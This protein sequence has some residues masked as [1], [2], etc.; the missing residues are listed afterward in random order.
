MVQ[1]GKDNVGQNNKMNLLDSL[2]FSPE[3][4]VSTFHISFNDYMH[5]HVSP[6]IVVLYFFS[7]LCN[8]FKD[9][10]F[11]AK[12]EKGKKNWSL[13]TRFLETCLQT[14]LVSEMSQVLFALK[15]YWFPYR[16]SQNLSVYIPSWWNVKSMFLLN[17]LLILLQVF[18]GNFCHRSSTSS[19]AMICLNT[20]YCAD[21]VQVLGVPVY[22]LEPLHLQGPMVT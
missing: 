2:T 4:L 10:S 11:F 5:L 22:F 9:L 1:L 19:L 13:V 18:C 17:V 3:H 8:F 6:P 7:I 14:F 21:S 16:C 12:K 20:G 15:K